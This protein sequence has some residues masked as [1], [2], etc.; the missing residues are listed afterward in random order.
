MNQ[1]IGSRE[2]PKL[3]GDV[4][5]SVDDADC[6]VADSTPS[7]A[8]PESRKRRNVTLLYYPRATIRTEK[9][10]HW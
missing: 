7:P 8:C 9:A 5:K 6:V 1:A 4:L 3:A 10:R 2:T